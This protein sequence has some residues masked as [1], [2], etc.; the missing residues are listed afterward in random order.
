MLCDLNSDH[1]FIFDIFCKSSAKMETSATELSQYTISNIQDCEREHGTTVVISPNE[2]I[3][4]VETDDKIIQQCLE[5]N[6]LENDED[7]ED[8]LVGVKDCDENEFS[9]EENVVEDSETRKVLRRKKSKRP[10]KKYEKI[11]RL[12][13]IYTCVDCPETFSRLSQL[14]AHS[15]IHTEDQTE[16]YEC[17]LCEEVF[18]R[19]K[20]L[21][22]H[23]KKHHRASLSCKMC[24]SKFTHY[25]SYRIHMRVHKGEKPYVCQECGAAFV[26]SGHLNIHKR[27]HTGEKPYTCDICNSNFKQISHLKTH[28]RTHTQD[29]PYRCEECEASFT[30]NSSLKRHR[31]SHSGEK[32]YKCA[33]CDMT[34][35]VK[36]NMQ[37][38]LY[39]H[40]G[41]KPYQCD[42]CPASFGQAI[43]LK[44]HKISHTGIKPFKCDQCDAA[45]SRKNNL[46][47]HQMTHNGNTPF[48]CEICQVG[49][50]SSGDLK[51]HKRIHAP[52]KPFRCDSCPAS[53]QQ[54]SSLTRHKMI[55]TGERP[56]RKKPES[57]PGSFKETG[58]KPYACEIC[59]ATFCE[60]RNLK[61]HII[62]LHDDVRKIMGGG[63][64]DAD[65]K[66]DGIIEKFIKLQHPAQVKKKVPE[67]V[68]YTINYQNPVV[69]TQPQQ[70]LVQPQQIEGTAQELQ[71]GITLQHVV[72]Q[73]PLTAEETVAAAPQTITQMPQLMLAQGPGQAPKPGKPAN[74]C[75]NHHAHVL[76]F[77]EGS[78]N[79]WQ[80]WC[81]CDPPNI[82]DQPSQIISTVPTASA[83]ITA[84]PS[85]VI[86]PDANATASVASAV[87]VTSVTNSSCTTVEQIEGQLMPAQIQVQ[88]PVG[89]TQT[90]GVIR[91]D[92]LRGWLGGWN[93]C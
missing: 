82:V 52:P 41:E 21:M 35:V 77:I 87:A 69:I 29:K 76:T 50:S 10:R 64:L 25:A 62:S 20:R 53:F 23:R 84:P 81:F 36:S 85:T 46:K 34:F 92:V 39:T 90:T 9:N 49:F 27:T 43:D 72:I 44:R 51:V 68:T 63:P 79:Q 60:K 30:Q 80:T 42:L 75:Q 12:S 18:D 67:Q 59:N 4:K 58:I 65:V 24:S 6:G 78:Y 88:L 83:I 2:I 16:K 37:R 7:E 57:K 73:Q 3:M 86:P 48:R 31:R 19:L 47:W 93:K 38:H 11:Q 91:E 32:P 40:T 33:F 56:L 13:R 8:D 45:F 54:Y 74:N 15:R 61:R 17:D 70:Q 14:R 55:H 22:S 71:Q 28:V 89:A 5:I 1:P 66:D 26:Q